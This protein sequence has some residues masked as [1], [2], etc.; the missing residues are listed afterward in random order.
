MDDLGHYF[1]LSVLKNEDRG[2]HVVRKYF[3]SS[4]VSLSS[5]Y[6]STGSDTGDNFVWELAGKYWISFIE[7]Q[8]SPN[9]WRV[10]E[11]AIG[12]TPGVTS[13]VTP[14]LDTRPC[15]KFWHQPYGDD[16][17]I[18]TASFAFFPC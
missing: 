4:F 14:D 6:C 1:C 2:G 16:A 11:A 8:I 13:F 15:D 9:D 5:S 12:D 7:N 3:L 10:T 18:C 17:M